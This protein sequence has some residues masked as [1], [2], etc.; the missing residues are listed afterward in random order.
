MNTRN[1][2]THVQLD[3]SGSHVTCK[4]AEAICERP[5]QSR[6]ITHRPDGPREGYA[7]TE[8]PSL[9]RTDSPEQHIRGVGGL[10]EVVRHRC[11]DGLLQLA[12]HRHAVRMYLQVNGLVSL[13]PSEPIVDLVLFRRWPL[14]QQVHAVD[15]RRLVGAARQMVGHPGAA[16]VRAHRPA[17]RTQAHLEGARG[18]T[19]VPAILAEVRSVPVRAPILRQ[20]DVAANADRIPRIALAMPQSQLA[21]REAPWPQ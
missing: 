7:L 20:R 16:D 8:C 2:Q 6:R 12:F 1:H 15:K 11:R 18:R 21:V 13:G 9:F 10:P 17:L 5:A 3:G 14:V 4:A 19:I